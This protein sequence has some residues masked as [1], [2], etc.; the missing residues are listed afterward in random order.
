M[1]ISSLLFYGFEKAASRIRTGYSSGSS[2][3]I[4]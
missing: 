1:I 4:D 2:S 3:I